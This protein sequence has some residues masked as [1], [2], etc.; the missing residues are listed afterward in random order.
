M[1]QEEMHPSINEFSARNDKIPMRELKYWIMLNEWIHSNY[2]VKTIETIRSRLDRV[3]KRKFGG[4]QLPQLIE[5]ERFKRYCDEL[6]LDV[7]EKTVEGIQRSGINVIT[8]LDERY[9]SM[10]RDI[11]DPPLVLFHRGELMNFDNC[12]AIVGT[13]DPSHFAHQKARALSR[14]LARKGYTIVSGLAKGID[15][16]AHCGA[17]D[18]NG[19]TVAVLGTKITDEIYPKE[20]SRLAADILKKGAIIS[21]APLFQKVR[22]TS[23]LKRN[24]IIS[25]I[26]MC[27]VVIEFGT[28]G[29]SFT[30]VKH[31]LK[32][33][34]QVFV[35]KPKARDKIAMKGYTDA[36]N[37]GAISFRSNKEII[38]YLKSSASHHPLSNFSSPSQQP[39]PSSSLHPQPPDPLPSSSHQ[40]P[41]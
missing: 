1:S 17:L 14:D 12:V 30:Q 39:N 31:A 13:R 41:E 9:P 37:E 34:R 10:L 18:V 35:L 6:D 2:R 28:S 29:G 23:F 32:Q 21:E 3:D 27:I 22:N 7:V 40:S 24:R 15:T 5:N 20:N 36:L 33:G 26:S 4:F 11:N 16:E 19:K 25:G 38:E 8:Y